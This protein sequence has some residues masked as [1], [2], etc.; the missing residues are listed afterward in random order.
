M[1]G[2]PAVSVWWTARDNVR[3]AASTFALVGAPREL[4][5][6]GGVV[7]ATARRKGLNAALDVAES[8]VGGG[9]VDCSW[10]DRG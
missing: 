3:R 5:Q 6:H 8:L 4:A 2:L 1:C 10:L 7:V 9:R